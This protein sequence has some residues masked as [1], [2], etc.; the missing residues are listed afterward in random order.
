MGLPEKRKTDLNL[1]DLTGITPD[2]FPAAV[3]AVIEQIA[4]IDK[5]MLAAEEK[6]KA[7]QEEQ[8]GAAKAAG[9]A[10][11]KA[12]KAKDSADDAAS[13]ET[14]W[15]KK[16]KAIDALQTGL[17]DMSDTQV[18]LAKAMTKEAKALESM[19]EA[20]S[21]QMEAL[22]ITQEHQLQIVELAKMLFLMGCANT[23]SS[24][25]ILQQL[26]MMLRDA[27]AEEMSEFA[28][29]EMQNVA[30]QLKAQQDA[31]IKLDKLRAEIDSHVEAINKSFERSKRLE[32]KAA[33]AEKHNAEQDERLKKAEDKNKKQD[34]EIAEQAK[35]DKEQDERLKKTE[36]KD[37]EQD[38][39]IKLQADK[40]TEQDKLIAE[41]AEKDK[42]QDELL[43]KSLEKNSEQDVAIESLVDKDTEH[44]RILAENIEKNEAQDA[45]IASQTEKNSEYDKL[46]ADL[47]SQ[48]DS[49]KNDKSTTIKATAG[50]IIAILALIAAIIQFFL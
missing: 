46:I 13:K 24:R 50:L 27:S 37:S 3:T 4:K 43:K 35:K 14:G 8:K 22:K 16:G 1:P 29:K 12:E 31:N 20:Q 28:R 32:E 30:A 25:T 48:L 21:G 10:L 39:A 36:E 33:L 47:F 5:K 15:F 34:D 11:K 17:S 42:V 18:D 45:H 44:D 19:A 23:A 9:N 49:I 40:N 2:Q 7:A 38:S 6:A 26:E 41:R